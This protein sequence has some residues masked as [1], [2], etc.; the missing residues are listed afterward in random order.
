MFFL[1]YFSQNVKGTSS[2][3]AI[4]YHSHDPTGQN[5]IVESDYTGGC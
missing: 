3:F 5:G 4:I 1:A 2:S